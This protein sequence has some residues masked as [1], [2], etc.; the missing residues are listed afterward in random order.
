MVGHRQVTSHK[1][2]KLPQQLQIFLRSLFLQEIQ[3]PGLQNGT[4][5]LAQN[6]AIFEIYPRI[7]AKSLQ[8]YSPVPI[9][10]IKQ[11]HGIKSFKFMHNV[12]IA[13]IYRDAAILLP[14]T[15]WVYLHSHLNSMLQRTRYI[16]KIVTYVCST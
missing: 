11:C 16:V 3:V 10:C 2:K 14:P 1:I 9:N 5:R 15:V 6:T 4:N 12:Y 8:I 13:E 7:S